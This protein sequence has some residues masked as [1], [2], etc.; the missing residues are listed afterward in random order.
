MDRKLHQ[1][2]AAVYTGGSLAGYDTEQTKEMLLLAW[3]QMTKWLAGRDLDV[4]DVYYGS[5]SPRH[6]DEALGI[7]SQNGSG[8]AHMR[9]ML[10]SGARREQRLQQRDFFGSRHK[11]GKTSISENNFW[12]T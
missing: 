8:L 1:L 6:L 3:D 5:M 4:E 2:V 11:D 7:A 9:E 10:G 12:C